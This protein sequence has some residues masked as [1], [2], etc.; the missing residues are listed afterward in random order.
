[1]GIWKNGGHGET[2]LQIS[3]TQRMLGWHNCCKEKDIPVDSSTLA[4]WAGVLGTKMTGDHVQVWRALKG[5]TTGVARTVIMSVVAEDGFEPWRRLH[6]QFEPK[7]VIRPGQVLADFAA[8]VS[9]PAKS[10]AETRELLMELERRMKMVRDLTE[11]GISDMHARS[12]LIGILD[13]QT[14]QHTAYKQADPFKQFKNSVL[15]FVDAAG[16]SQGGLTKSD[17]MQ[18]GRVEEG[19]AN[20]G[21]G[22]HGSSESS[23]GAE[24]ENVWAVS[25]LGKE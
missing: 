16:F 14:R 10:I 17:P 2:T 3:L 20:A 21:S 11:Q 23:M 8:M 7:L 4:K 19:T 15:V 6:M 25:G 12:A 22:A 18:V 13:P 5:L 1:M 24:K 9:R